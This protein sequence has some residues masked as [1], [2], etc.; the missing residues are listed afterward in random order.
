M[1]RITALLVV[2]GAALA[3]LPAEAQFGN[4]PPPRPPADVPNGFPAQPPPVGYP[5]QAAPQYSPPP[6]NQ[7]R[8]APAGRQPTGIQSQP[9]APPPGAA[10]APGSQPPRVAPPSPT[11]GARNAPAPAPATAPPL[12]SDASLQ[13]DD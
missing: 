13:P 12:P 3:A 1:V 7:V 8:P 4:T 9:L 5:G 6:Q 11:Q 10:S 2:I